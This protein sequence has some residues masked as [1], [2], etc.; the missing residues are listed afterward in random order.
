MNPKTGA[1]TFLLG[2][3]GLGLITTVVVAAS[4]ATPQKTSAVRPSPRR[5]AAQ[6]AQSRPRAA[7]VD[8]AAAD[9]RLRAGAAD[10]RRAR[11]LRLRGAASRDPRSTC[12]ATAAAASR[13]TRPTS[14]ASSRAAT[15]RATCSSGTTHGFGCAICVDV[16]RESMQL[17]ASGADVVSIRA[18]IERRWAPGNAAG[19]TPTPAP[20]A[21]K[22][23][24]AIGPDARSSA[25]RVRSSVPS[26][27]EGVYMGTLGA[28][29]HRDARRQSPS[30][31]TSSAIPPTPP[32]P[33]FSRSNRRASSIRRRGTP[34]SS[35]SIATAVVTRSPD[36]RPPRRRRA[37]LDRG[38]GDRVTSA[39]HPNQTQLAVL[40]VEALVRDVSERK[41]REDQI[42][43]GRYQML[44]AEKMAALGQTIS[45]VAHELNNPLAT[46][47]SWAER[48][49]ER[50]VDDKTKQGLEVILGESERAAR[51]VRNLLTFAR[52]RQTTRAMVD[53]NQVVRETLA[54]RAYEQ[55]VSNISV[56]EALATGPAGGLCRRPSDQAGPAQSPDQRRAGLH[57]RQRPRHDR[58]AHL[59]RHRSRVARPRGQRRWAGRSG[60]SPGQ[61]LRSVLHDEGSR[62]G[63]RARPDRR[64]RDRAGARRPHLADVEAGPGRVVLHRAAGRRAST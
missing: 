29:S 8:A 43:D 15:P 59:A 26:V 64:L 48:L 47:L 62:P 20:P 16:A 45:G 58:R 39:D 44:Q 57:R 30:E 49:S 37:D 1:F 4:Q 60:R 28:N 9:R 14:R 40:H 53:L 3:A 41:K 27:R 33:S 42:R 54:L 38:L 17:Y 35:C 25:T 23:S 19:R 6:A 36:S 50:N 22:I 34:S 24:A 52:K 12:R 5:P 61:S 51:I 63:H 10:G 11:D 7:R 21:K 13:A 2:L 55:R 32:K 31:A 46:I 56:V 18:A